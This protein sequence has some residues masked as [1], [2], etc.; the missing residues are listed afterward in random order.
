MVPILSS[1]D[2]VAT[3]HGKYIEVASKT[4][5]GIDNIKQD[6]YIA[7]WCSYAYIGNA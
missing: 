1:S 3:M 2:P 6:I 5:S 7:K 4:I